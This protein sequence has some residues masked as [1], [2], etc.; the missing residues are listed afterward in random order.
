VLLSD[1]GEGLRGGDPFMRRIQL[2]LN[3]S[4]KS[5]YVFLC[6]MRRLMLEMNKFVW[7]SH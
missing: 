6:W 4:S 3:L 2:S 7:F 1:V 5:F